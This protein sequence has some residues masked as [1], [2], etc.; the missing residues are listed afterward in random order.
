MY[1]EVWR[2][3]KATLGRDHPETL[4]DKFNLGVASCW[5]KRW[6]EGEKLLSEVVETRKRVL[7]INH[8][9]TLDAMDSLSAAQIELGKISKGLQNMG[10]YYKGKVLHLF[11]PMV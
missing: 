8:P 1:E 10:K 6:E 5:S 11:Y 3:S 4:E 7:G 9:D 2:Q